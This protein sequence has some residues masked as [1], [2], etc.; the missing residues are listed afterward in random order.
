M[1]GLRCTLPVRIA[2]GIAL[3]S[4][5]PALVIAS[6]AAVSQPSDLNIGNNEHV[7]L[8]ASRQARQDPDAMTACRLVG[9]FHSAD[10]SLKELFR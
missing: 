1:A 6:I 9:D 3:A 7:L 5:I 4:G 10:S 8:D 2:T